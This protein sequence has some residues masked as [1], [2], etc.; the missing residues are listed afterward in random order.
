MFASGGVGWES[1]SRLRCYSVAQL[2]QALADAASAN[3]VGKTR[4]LELSSISDDNEMSTCLAL[5]ADRGLEGFPAF[6]I[7]DC[8]LGAGSLEFLGAV[9]RK[10]SLGQCGGGGWPNAAD[11][12]EATE[13]EIFDLFGE[14]APAASE[15][16]IAAD[17]SERVAASFSAPAPEGALVALSISGCAGTATDAWS[18]LWRELPAGLVELDLAGNALSDHAVSAL[19]GA[20]R[21]V[22]GCPARLLLPGNRCKDI[23]RLCGLLAAGLGPSEVLDLSETALNDKS[24]AQ[25]SE[26]LASASCVPIG[27]LRLAGCRR[28]TSAGLRRLASSLSTGRLRSLDLTDTALCDAGAAALAATLPASAL[29]CGSAAL[30]TGVG[31]RHLV[32]AATAALQVQ[33]LEVDDDGERVRWR[34]CS[35]PADVLGFPRATLAV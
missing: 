10:S 22:G 32:A 17:F 29:R 7:S 3:S 2:H 4:C 31:A 18:P 33:S 6:R 12:P 20:L 21:R 25:L 14:A 26:A 11:E 9:M 30:M 16:A 5:L 27:A 34:R 19:M 35:D 1:A 23:E 15:E 28:L 24:A 13:E 8:V